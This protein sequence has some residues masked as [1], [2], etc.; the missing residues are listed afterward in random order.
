MF[1]GDDS[2]PTAVITAKEKD[3]KP[4]AEESAATLRLDRRQLD[5][6]E[7]SL[8][9][10]W[11]FGVKTGH[12]V[13]VETRTGDTDPESV[14]FGMKDEFQDLMERCADALNLTVPAT[15]AAWNYLCDAWIAGTKFWEVEIV[16]RLIESQTGGFDEVLRRLEE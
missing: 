6:M 16:A 2:L 13:M 4:L 10:A 9:E 5:A 14:I 11:F 15:I 3:L 12:N 1:S 7:A 8:H